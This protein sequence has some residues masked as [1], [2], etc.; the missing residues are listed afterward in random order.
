MQ[1]F[2]LKSVTRSSNKL[3]DGSYKVFEKELGVFDSL[4]KAEAFMR[5]YIDKIKNDSHFNY[6]DYHCFVVYEKTLNR[7]LSKKW[8]SVCE[9]EG[10]RSYL[11][12]GTLYCDS[13]YDDACEKPFRGRPAETIKLK[14]GDI[15]WFWW[16]GHM[17]PCL[18]ASLP[19]TDEH[20]R[21][22]AE[23]Y[24][25]D[26]GWDYVDDSYTV[27]TC[28][29]GHEHPECWRCMPYYGKISKRTLQRLQACKRRE[30]AEAA[31]WRKEQERLEAEGKDE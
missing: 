15:A 9:F 27:Y 26:L 25:D 2:E 8:N 19:I 30:E 4:E 11:P 6:S 29:M 16:Y 31:K 23:N 7:G 14:V 22:L 28:D 20:Y 18:V 21:E 3:A 10:I 24:G 17:F 5:M 1:I 12:D 13:P